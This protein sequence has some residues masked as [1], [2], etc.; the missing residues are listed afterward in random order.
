M[1][2]N[3]LDSKFL[4]TKPVVH[5][6]QVPRLAPAVSGYKSEPIVRYSNDGGSGNTATQYK[7]TN[8]TVF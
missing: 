4:P 2:S 3:I 5:P 6:S 8:A 1:S 7:A